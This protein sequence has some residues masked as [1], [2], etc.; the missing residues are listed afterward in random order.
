MTSVSAN[1]H[2]DICKFFI[3]RS[4]RLKI[5]NVL[6]KRFRE[7]QNKHF[8]LDNLFSE[9]CTVCE[10]LGEKTVVVDTPQ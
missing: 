4:I 10:T 9:N 1:S 2:K 3:S 5:T 8:V 6:V 7:N